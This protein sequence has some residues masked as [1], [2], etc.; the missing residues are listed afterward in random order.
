[1]SMW[2]AA[3]PFSEN[4]LVAADVTFQVL[5][6][7]GEKYV[8]PEYEHLEGVIEPKPK[9]PAKKPRATGAEN[10]RQRPTIT[11]RLCSCMGGLVSHVRRSRSDR[12]TVD[13]SRRD[14][15]PGHGVTGIP[16]GV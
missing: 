8:N 1:L 16:H 5:Y 11:R 3:R 2:I 4:F 10:G 15:Y 9:A 14:L 6:E 7:W 12:A 13:K